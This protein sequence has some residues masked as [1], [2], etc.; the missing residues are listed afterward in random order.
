MVKTKNQTMK[1]ENRQLGMAV[2]VVMGAEG[3]PMFVASD[4]AKALG[5]RDA[6]RCGRRQALSS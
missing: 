6:T 5:Y 2:R 3:E 4:L 1:F